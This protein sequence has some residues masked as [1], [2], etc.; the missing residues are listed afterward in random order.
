[1]RGWKSCYCVSSD[2]ERR[3]ETRERRS[4]DLIQSSFRRRLFVES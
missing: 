3:N 1:M 2:D 4:D